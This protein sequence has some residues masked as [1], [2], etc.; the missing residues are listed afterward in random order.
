ME[1]NP[2]K[3]YSSTLEMIEST[4]MLKLNNLTKKHN[5]KCQV[6]KTWSL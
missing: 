4:L 5:I 6:Y 2:L 3:I 1:N